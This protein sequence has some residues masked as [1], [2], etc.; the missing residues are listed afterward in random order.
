MTTV[1]IK[2]DD[3]EQL[4]ATVT[5]LK[6]L[7]TGL[8][9]VLL[10]IHRVSDDY[11]YDFNDDTFKASGWTSATQAMTEI[12]AT[13]LPGQYKWDFDTSAITNATADDAYAFI[14]TCASG[15]NMPQRGEI[16][17]GQYL[18]DVTEILGLVQSNFLIDTV[19]NDA[20]GNM[21]SSRLRIFP[22]KA[23][24]V[25]GTNVIHTYTAAATYDSNDYCTG[26]SCVK[27]S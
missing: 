8:S 7:Q 21:T 3:T 19:V 24:K 11:I 16:K 20:S 17:V 25:A 13:N 5:L 1:R 23:D 10:K 12:D 27:E 9:D 15:D 14:V 22:T 18:D 4:N 6:T 26:Y 2:T